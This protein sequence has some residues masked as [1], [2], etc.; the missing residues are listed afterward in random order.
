MQPM[1]AAVEI[2]DLN[3]HFNGAKKA[4]SAVSLVIE[5]GEMVALIGASGSGKSTL[6][7]HIA[8]LV[9]ADRGTGG[10]VHVAGRVIQSEG[11]ISG[12]IRKCRT[13]IGFIF[14]QFNLVGRLSVET[15]VL[16]GLLSRVP[17]WRSLPGW[18]TATEKALAM[19]ALTRVGIAQHA[20]R[21]ASTLSGGQQQRA[22]IARTL[23]QEASL[24]LADEPIAS[25][26]PES[27]RKVMETLADI[28]RVDGITVIVTLHQ[29]DVARRYCHR[30]VALREGAIVF[31]GPASS[32]S[33]ERLRAIYGAEADYMTGQAVPPVRGEQAT[34]WHPAIE[35]AAAVS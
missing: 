25:L 29:V 2:K 7:R 35:T 1:T 9:A 19:A 34:P 4:L 5:P 8:G 3:K 26:D 21:R 13:R 33:D 31:D 24:I 11:R 32:L 17:L 27:L 15:N 23:V 30:V 16:C 22:A 10:T 18:F 20:K 14:Q 6:L 12:N 28:N